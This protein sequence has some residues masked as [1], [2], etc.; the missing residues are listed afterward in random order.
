MVAESSQPGLVFWVGIRWWLLS[1]SKNW[2]RH[3]NLSWNQKKRMNNSLQLGL[4][5]KTS[6]KT[7]TSF[8]LMSGLLVL[9]FVPLIS[10]NLNGVDEFQNVLHIWGYS[11]ILYLMIYLGV[12]WDT[13]CSFVLHPGIFFNPFTINKSYS[14]AAMIHPWWWNCET[15]FCRHPQRPCIPSR[16]VQLQITYFN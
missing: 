9:C 16:I 14:M 11:W 3:T 2:W 13:V 10:R 12:I 15:I 5:I 8:L 4:N 1:Y 7:T 6:V